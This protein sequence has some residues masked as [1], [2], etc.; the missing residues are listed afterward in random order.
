MGL[1]Y[2][3]LTE[4][5]RIEIYSLRK[6]KIPMTH[7]A[8]QLGRP[9]Q[10]LYRELNRNTGQ[11]G[12]RPK[13]AQSKA[14]AR[15]RRP[16]RPAKMTGAICLYVDEKIRLD[17]SPEQ[18]SDSLFNDPVGPR[19]RLSHE[20]IYQYIYNDKATGGD[21]Y[22]HLRQGKTKRKKRRHRPDLR[23][24][25]RN[26]I[27]IEDR[28][29]VVETRRRLGDWEADLVCGAGASGYLVTLV[30]RKSRLTRIGL[31]WSKFAD[32]VTAEILRLLADD[33]VETITFDNGKEFAGHAEIACRL[34]C[35]CYFADPY[36]SWQRGLNEN[37]N[38]LIRQYFPKGT[39]LAGVTLEEL[40][41]V[42]K[43]LNQRP[44]KC[45]RFKPPEIVY[46][47]GAA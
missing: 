1:H 41:R 4:Q 11:R 9:V 8:R 20:T 25:I 22:K 24:H 33:V 47:S 21:L 7:I 36:S 17:W 32:E 45:L 14:V 16:R 29:P 30:E 10:T 39:S 12:Y 19:A 15:C 2:R 37:T 5:E 38:G 46:Y 31:T 23:G 42:E 28:P 34:G 3:H 18:I 43:R 26:R 44:R 6:A 27:G 40:S 35:K 13:Q